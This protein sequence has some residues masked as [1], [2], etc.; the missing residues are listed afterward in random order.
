MARFLDNLT[1]Y[2]HRPGGMYP[3]R[4]DAESGILPISN[5]KRKQAVLTPADAQAFFFQQET[6]Q[7]AMTV[8]IESVSVFYTCGVGAGN[9]TIYAALIRPT[10]NE[11]WAA[12]LMEN[13]SLNGS[14]VYLSHG[15]DQL[16]IAAGAATA[17][18]FS[19]NMPDFMLRDGAGLWI[20]CGMF[21]GDTALVDISYREVAR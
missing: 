14:I 11:L 17:A 20:T 6:G 5:P 12:P 15:I 4:E 8:L 2:E 18:Y 10:G 21:V 1:G 19:Y 7:N 13:A 9:R 16:T 3:Y